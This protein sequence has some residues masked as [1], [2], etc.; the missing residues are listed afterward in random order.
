MQNKGNITF[1]VQ[2]MI[3]F[4]TAAYGV[5][6]LVFVYFFYHPT[7]G[8]QNASIDASRLLGWFFFLYVESYISLIL[9]SYWAFVNDITTPESASRGY[10][11]IIFGTQLGG[12]LFTLLGNRL[13]AD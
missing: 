6:G 13:S 3:Y 7:I 4:L 12:F 5:I 9:H 1:N 10:G 11:L 2:K 8:L